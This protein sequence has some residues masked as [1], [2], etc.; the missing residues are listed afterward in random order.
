M[1]RLGLLALGGWC[2]ATISCWAQVA[3]PAAGSVRDC[4]H[5]AS[6]P[7]D[8]SNEAAFRKRLQAWLESCKQAGAEDTTDPRLKIAWAR[9]LS[10]DGKRPEAVALLRAAA[11][12]NDAEANYELYET[13]KSYDRGDVNKTPLVPRVEAERSL[14]KAAEL[15]HPYSMWILAV[16]LDRGSTVKRDPDDA[17]LWA[18]R[19]MAK[20]PKD[21]SQADIEVRL[22]HFLAKSAKS[23]NKARGI[24]ILERHARSRGDAQSYLAI[25]L[26]SSDPARARTL[27][28]QAAKTYPG[29][30][31][32]TL[33]DMLIK[34][35]GGPAD[36]KRALSLLRGKP[37]DVS[38]I[39]AALGRLYLDGRLVPRD[40]K[41]AVR[42]IR[43][44][45]IWSHESRLQL[46]GLL[47]A[48]PDIQIEYPGG[49]LYDAT[50]AAELGEPGA[51]LALIDLKLSKSS[52]FAD[53]AGG[54]ALAERAASQ[55]V[56]GAAQRAQA[57]RA[58]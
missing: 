3:T 7:S 38:A 16:L 19:A 54:C 53:R 26:R 51:L 45:T 10:A 28:E 31:V 32:P 24:G 21:T 6:V 15:G 9:A 11:A 58:N 23:E 41:E 29:H 42:L 2:A 30:A 55:R 25:A 1:T 18:E 4:L 8:I 52:Q 34:G 43:T 12:Q 5:H 50:E 36:T 35:E 27:L 33:A 17:I 13:H 57:C 49:V 46:I 22:G 14:R 48:N 39:K 20:P 47:A 40:V 37:Q 44:D 56:D